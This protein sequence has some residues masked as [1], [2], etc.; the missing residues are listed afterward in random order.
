MSHAARVSEKASAWSH[1]KAGHL[2]Y[3]A[4]RLFFSLLGRLRQGKITIIDGNRTHV[5]G[6][7]VTG[8]G[9]EATVRVNHPRFYSSIVLGGSIG[10][11]EAYMTGH[12]S[13]DDLPA[14]FR[15]VLLNRSVFRGMDRGLAW[16]KGP[17]YKL[18]HLLRRDT[19][20]G[21]RRNIADHYDLGNEFYAQFLDKTMTYSCGIFEREEST[22]KEASMTKY[23]RIANKLA[24]RSTDHVIEIGTGWG[25]FALHAAREYGCRVT[26]TTISKAQYEFA[27]KRFQEAGLEDR[28]DL[29][30][31]DY[32][33]V[34]GKYDK[35]VSIEMIEAVGHHYLDAFF[36]ACS[37]LLKQD[38]MMML[39]AITISDQVFDQHKR[40][41]DFIKRYIFPGSCIPSVTAV[42]RSIARVTDLR[43]DHLE[44]ITPHYAKTLR[45][46]RERFFRNLKRVK[47]LGFPDSFIRMWEYYLSYCEAGFQERYL[48]DVQ[49]RLIKPLSRPTPLLPQL[50]VES[51][52]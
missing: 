37:N 25:G 9:L 40:S 8:D 32:R 35:L 24:L 30:F 36:R 22:L 23:R 6:R 46:W 33:D 52:S 20:R 21:S 31:K 3:L 41:V 47:T 48:G 19:R 45:M 38:G 51:L 5:F 1:V 4:Q 34:G 28:V 14:L 18:Y 17:A 29:L 15:I 16:L 26:T 11:G 13:A 12:W 49:M 43:L 39:Q 2:E 42:C 50:D 10:A 27:R 44:D 7:H